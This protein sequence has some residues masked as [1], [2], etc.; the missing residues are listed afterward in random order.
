M[1]KLLVIHIALTWCLFSF[2]QVQFYANAPEKA[3][4]Q[5]H[6]QLVFTIEN[7]NAKNF[8][9]P[10]FEN[11]KV[12]SG[13]NQSSSY[14]NIN[15]KVSSS[16]SLV[17]YLEPLQEGTLKIGK[18]TVV[19]NGNEMETKPLSIEV[20]SARKANPP[21][22]TQ[23]NEPI[24][25]DESW[26][27]DAA[28]NIFARLYVDNTNPYVGEQIFVTAKLYLRVNT[29]GSQIT[30]FPDFDNCWKQEIEVENDEP[31][32]EEYQGKKYNTYT[33]GKYALFPLKEGEISI[34]PV[35]L[36]TLLLLSVPKEENFFG[37]RIQTMGYEQV[38]YNYASNALNLSVKPLPQENKPVNFNGAVGNFDIQTS[39]DSSSIQLGNPI[40]YTVRFQGTGNLMAINEPEIEFPKFI[41]VFDPESNEVIS[42]KS[43][44]VN[45][46]KEFEYIL[47]PQRPGQ[48]RIPSLEFSYFDLQTESYVSVTSPYYDINV[49]GEL[50]QQILDTLSKIDSFLVN[51]AAY[52]IIEDYDLRQTKH[53]SSP[54][55]IASFSLPTIAYGLFFL[56]VSW[57]KRNPINWAAV[58]NKQ[59]LKI[60]KKRLK[61]AKTYLDL[62]DKT[63]FYNEVFTALYQYIGDKFNV[64]PSEL[65]IDS[66]NQL[67]IEKGI[68]QTVNDEFN[69]V[70][71]HS[72][73]ALYSP[74]AAHQMQD[75]YQTVINWIINFEHEIKQ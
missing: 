56:F 66:I 9:A 64:P 16:I 72:E 35:K 6:F 15:G 68:N 47:V 21:P 10:Q 34:S 69:T 40:H 65:S 48:F 51:Q 3:Y 36:N 49:E 17:Y 53:V 20:L 75:D 63:A 24:I 59:A 2:A 60:A 27:E 39:I 30:D 37:M 11:C 62:N 13:P 38:E 42:K 33:I 57:R 25:D 18:A 26:K 46:K 55:V 71:K 74:I 29:Y 12:L 7:G 23:N 54:L 50:P 1:K 41:D 61:K 8:K 22:Q 70:I 5:E 31:V 19:V 14:Q 4:L 58:K 32:V 43:N 73:E 67:F 45:G 52:P 44:Y 28:N